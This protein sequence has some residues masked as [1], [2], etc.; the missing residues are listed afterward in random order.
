M[1]DRWYNTKERRLRQG[2]P[3]TYEKRE[4][5]ILKRL[6]FCFT[7]LSWASSDSASS[8]TD[9]LFSRNTNMKSTH[10]TTFPILLIFSGHSKVFQH[11]S[12]K[13]KF[14]QKY[15]ANHGGIY[16]I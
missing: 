2:K 6:N 1:G 15:F 14:T 7:N 3:K 13:S 10:C 11:V 5:K 16:I 12:L 8:D 9:Q 4:S